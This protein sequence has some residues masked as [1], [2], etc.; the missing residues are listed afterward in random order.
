MPLSLTHDTGARPAV[1]QQDRRLQLRLAETPQDRLA[2]KR[3][4][5]EVFVAERGGDGPLVDHAVRLERD[6]FDPFCD[7][8]LLIDPARDP[9]A[10]NH[11]VGAYRLMDG[12]GAAQA[13]GFYSA[14]EYD[15]APLLHSG[16]KLL[17]LGRSCVHPE[18]RG[19]TAVFLLWNGVADYAQARGIELLFG[20][21]SFAGTDVDALAQPLSWLH[22]N[23]LAPKDLRVTARGASAHRMD[24]LPASALDRTVAL[25]GIPAL[26]RSYLR[27]GGSVGDGA[28]VDHAFN[29][30]DVF[31]L[32]DM[33]AMASRRRGLQNRHPPVR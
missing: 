3:L 8:L 25:E 13:G 23:H 1:I 29:T 32:L 26:I 7:H 11:V 16:R 15:L 30:T 4:R 21:A 19:G 18:Y 14:S 9:A 12:A 5:Y 31:L 33:A 6:R 24:L 17:E 27:L 10:L 20:V 28:F 2:A 22:H